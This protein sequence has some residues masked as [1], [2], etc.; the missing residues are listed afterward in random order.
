MARIANSG[1]T[2]TDSIVS[3][4]GD[5]IGVAV[6]GTVNWLVPDLHGST[7][8]SLAADGAG[9]ANAIRYDPYG[10]VLAT[11][12]P[13]G[14]PAP[15]GEKAWKYRGRLDISPEG[16]STPLYDAGARFYSVGRDSGI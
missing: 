15:V 16:I 8:A 4:A 9:L 1:G 12:R 10:E 2:T 13:A 7:G 6:G 14:A 11:G 3:P 5:R